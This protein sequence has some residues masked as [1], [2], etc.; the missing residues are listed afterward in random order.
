VPDYQQKRFTATFNP[1]TI[2]YIRLKAKNLLN[3]PAW[4]IRAGQETFIFADE[5]VVN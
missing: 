5:I 1:K 3:L 4:H 2:R